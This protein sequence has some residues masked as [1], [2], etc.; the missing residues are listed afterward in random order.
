MAQM[1]SVYNLIQILQ[2]CS[3]KS[4]TKL[5]FLAVQ[6]AIFPEVTSMMPAVSNTPSMLSL[7]NYF[8]HFSFT[9][10]NN[11]N[12]LSRVNKK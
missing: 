12:F 8:T 5:G 7:I 1:H 2:P 3:A 4:G 6:F 9:Y 10:M 11:Q